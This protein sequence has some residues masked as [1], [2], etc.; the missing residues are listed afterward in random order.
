[1]DCA[2]LICL[3]SRP[4]VCS[5]VYICEPGKVHLPPKLGQLGGTLCCLDH[6]NRPVLGVLSIRE[7]PQLG[8]Q[9]AAETVRRLSSAL[10]AGIHLAQSGTGRSTQR[11]R[12]GPRCLG[13]LAMCVHFVC[14]LSIDLFNFLFSIFKYTFDSA[15]TPGR[16]LPAEFRL[17]TG[18]NPMA[19]QKL[20]LC[21]LL[22]LNDSNDLFLIGLISS[23]NSTHAPLLVRLL[24][25]GLLKG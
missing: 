5:M 17:P 10:V 25:S 16:F 23:A 19:A 18:T 7:A 3:A 24:N 4:A 15:R 6:R 9:L 14:I 20:G 22:H 8:S 1:M 21:V 12:F 2:R 13:C 11:K